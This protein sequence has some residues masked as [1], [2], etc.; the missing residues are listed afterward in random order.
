[1]MKK[2]FSYSGIDKTG[3]QVDG[4]F[5]CVTAEKLTAVLRQKGITV[6][7]L[8]RNYESVEKATVGVS[9]IIFIGLGLYFFSGSEQ[10]D[11]PRIES[12]VATVKKVKK[13]HVNPYPPLPP[14]YQQLAA[15]KEQVNLGDSDA[16]YKLAMLY[17]AGGV[18]HQ[19]STKAMELFKKA[20]TMGSQD[21]Q[22]RMAQHLLTT[23]GKDGKPDYYQAVEWLDRAA[24]KGH[25]QATVRLADMYFYG[26]GI[27]QDMKAAEKWLT[28]LAAKG[29]VRASMKLE[30]IRMQRKM[31]EEANRMETQPHKEIKKML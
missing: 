26:D 3:K 22:Y 31:Q 4:L 5:H 18:V 29:H 13:A 30:R 24:G 6:T 14:Q 10:N 23:S 11:A 1:M 17:D 8:R 21:A 28:K 2:P 12:A 7:N 15:I 20:A 19:N 27:A 16:Q 25:E 9:V